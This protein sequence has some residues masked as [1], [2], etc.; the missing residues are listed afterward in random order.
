MNWFFRWIIK[1]IFI[2][3]LLAAIGYIG[4]I[5]YNIAIEDA[6]KK[7]EAGVRKGVSKGI[8]DGINP[9]KWPGKM[10]GK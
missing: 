4:F 5:V 7:I 6:T 10:F 2:I 8:G 1:L 3:G 9:L